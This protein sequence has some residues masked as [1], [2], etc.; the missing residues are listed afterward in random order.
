MKCYP[1]AVR[2][3]LTKALFL[4]GM[5]MEGK[6]QILAQVLPRAVLEPLT[7][8][9][10]VALP[11]IVRNIGYVVIHK[12][13][14]RVGRESRVRAT[15]RGLERVE[16][17]RL[18]DDAVPNNDLY[19]VDSGQYLNI[20][21]EHMLIEIRDGAYVLVDRGS[22][23]GSRVGDVA[24]G[25][26]DQLGAAHLHDGDII[27]LGVKSSPYQYRFISFDGFV[28]MKKKARHA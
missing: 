24:I 27:Q 14:F 19:L 11:Q 12:F 22:A 17:H 4:K 26:G 10:R 25:G 5:T 21:R 28:L 23:C 3:F 20:S 1:D 16:R 18:V 7:P 6:E 13:P 9:A 8:E 15:E 2:A